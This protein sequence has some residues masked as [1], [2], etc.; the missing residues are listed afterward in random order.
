MPILCQ[1]VELDLV[2]ARCMGDFVLCDKKHM[3]YLIVLDEET[4]LS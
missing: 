4:N 3:C 2:Y 1:Q